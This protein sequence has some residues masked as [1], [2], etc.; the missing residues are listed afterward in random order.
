VGE[1]EVEQLCGS[2]S[3]VYVY[4]VYVYASH[5]AARTILASARIPSYSHDEIQDESPPL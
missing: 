4:P 5:R 1:G 3:S 2:R